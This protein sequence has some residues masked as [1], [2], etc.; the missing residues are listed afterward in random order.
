MYEETPKKTQLLF[1]MSPHSK[2]DGRRPP[3]V[4][5]ATDKKMTAK[6]MPTDGPLAFYDLNT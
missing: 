6:T 2:Q 5:R 4:T 1:V 3:E